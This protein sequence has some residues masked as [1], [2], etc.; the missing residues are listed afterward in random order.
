MAFE[1]IAETV[2]VVI[3][4]KS[5]KLK[6]LTWMDLADFEAYTI[7]LQAARCAA[8]VSRVRTAAEIDTV[9]EATAR[10]LR[11]PIDFYALTHAAKTW[12][13]AIWCLSRAAQ[14]SGQNVDFSALPASCSIDDLNTAVE[15][16][17]PA[18]RKTFRPD[19]KKTSDTPTSE[20]QKENPPPT[21]SA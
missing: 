12:T 5:L 21:T 16:V 13:G 18:W 2:A 9:R 7:A 11:S 15:A 20:N 10:V 3:D 14:N 19:E 8:A 6:T 1:G 17:L 4:G